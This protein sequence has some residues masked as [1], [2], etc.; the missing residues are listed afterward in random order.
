[1]IT[2][3]IPT[4]GRR[5]AVAFLRVPN[6]VMSQPCIEIVSHFRHK[7]GY[8]QLN[9]S[10]PHGPLH[11]PAHRAAYISKHGP[12]SIP[13]GWE[14]DHICG[15]PSCVN[16]KHLRALHPTDHKRITN[17]ARGEARREAARCVWEAEG[18]NGAQLAARFGVARAIGARWIKRFEAD[19]DG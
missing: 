11:I 3:P 17:G 15:N 16:R 13:E 18:L 5:K 2:S 8:V 6:P 7:R 10:T 12:S 1:M 9:V 4:K 14:I 19:P